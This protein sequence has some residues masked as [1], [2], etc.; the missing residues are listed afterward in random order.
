VVFLVAFCNFLEKLTLLTASLHNLIPCD[1]YIALSLHA[2][3]FSE[4]LDHELIS[5][6]S[7]L[8]SSKHL[9]L[10]PFMLHVMVFKQFIDCVLVLM[11]HSFETSN[12]KQAIC[13]HLMHHEI[14][15]VSVYIE[16]T[17]PHVLLS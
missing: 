2:I 7:S 5:S 17:L 8:N 10:D 3:F 11:S 6:K 1:P 15:V 9:A 16:F 14:Q 13:G 4:V 12:L